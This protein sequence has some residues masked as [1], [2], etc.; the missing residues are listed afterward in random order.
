MLE[1]LRHG[2]LSKN[3][4]VSYPCPY[5][6]TFKL[7]TATAWPWPTLSVL[8]HR[9]ALRFAMQGDQPGCQHLVILS[10]TLLLASW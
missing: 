4:M 10:E 1:M 8:H 9:H 6:I 7:R 2:R 3:K 5:I